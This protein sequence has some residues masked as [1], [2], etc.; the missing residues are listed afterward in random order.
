MEKRCI[1]DLPKQ[2]IVSEETS[3]TW[4]EVSLRKA[5]PKPSRRV[6]GGL[7]ARRAAGPGG[8]GGSPQKAPDPEGSSLPG[9]GG[10]GEGR[11]E[12]LQKFLT[13]KRG[14]IFINYSTK[15]NGKILR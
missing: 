6:T 1:F 4:N 13:I 7:K 8:G 12:P 15:K 11:N 9:R 14:G 3:E 5:S 2:Y 10:R